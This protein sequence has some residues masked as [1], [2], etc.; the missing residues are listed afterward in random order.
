[1]MKYNSCLLTLV[2]SQSGFLTNI[3][4]RNI[5]SL[6]NRFLK[7]AKANR[8]FIANIFSLDGK[9]NNSLAG[10]ASRRLAQNIHEFMEGNH[11]I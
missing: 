7:C 2:S 9:Q 8:A 11:E 10:K 6:G 4:V 3:S 1:M 5:F